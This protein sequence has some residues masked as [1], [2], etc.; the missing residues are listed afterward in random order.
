MRL[1][2][3]DYPLSRPRIYR[4][5]RYRFRAALRAPPPPPSTR[6]A[7]IQLLFT[8]RFQK[9]LTIPLRS[10]FASLCVWHSGKRGFFL[11]QCQDYVYKRFE[12]NKTSFFFYTEFLPS[13]FYSYA[14]RARALGFL[15]CRLLAGQFTS[16]PVTEI[17]FF[18]IFKV[19]SFHSRLLLLLLF[20]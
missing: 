3:P 17:R 20:L 13:S 7:S 15:C 1:A 12:G 5:F 14:F 9:N 19:S 4:P 16:R 10:F 18:F 2:I 11:F 6:F 8:P